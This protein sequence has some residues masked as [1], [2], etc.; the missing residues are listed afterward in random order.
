MK[1][2][3][4]IDYTDIDYFEY[5]I[6]YKNVNFN[7]KKENN[8]TILHNICF[9]AVHPEKYVKLLL[10]AKTINV[11]AVTTT[12]CSALHLACTKLNFKLIKLL[13]KA[14][15]NP[16]IKISGHSVPSAN[17]R[18][19]MDNI[20]DALNDE[21]ITFKEYIKIMLLF[22][23][24]KYTGYH[25]VRTHII[26][27]RYDHRLFDYGL[28]RQYLHIDKHELYIIALS[29]LKLLRNCL[30]PLDLVLECIEHAYINIDKFY[31]HVNEKNTELPTNR[32]LKRID[33]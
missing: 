15:A 9:R 14:G 18:V 11:N 2:L 19:P 22:S 31:Y 29:V 10:D 28:S 3:F 21:K 27:F 25:S 12:N 13:L 5:L 20:I 26:Y 33:N 6:K 23:H 30:M 1:S 17:G 8:W 24:Y 16:N 4:D 7:E 32:T